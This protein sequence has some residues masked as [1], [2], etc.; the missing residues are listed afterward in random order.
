[1]LTFI[2]IVIVVAL[3]VVFA[4]V[5]IVPQG[6]QWTVER[7]G[8]YT[9]TLMPGLNP[10]VPFMDRIGRKINMMEQVLDI[11]SQE[12]ISRDNA[13]VAI[14]A[15]CF[16]RGRS[17]ARRLRGQQPRTGDR[18]PD[19]DQLP[20][21]ARLDGAGRNAVATRQHQQPPAAHRR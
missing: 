14:D 10:V 4:G 20:Y 13:N 19:H 21:R 16:I 18:Q 3:I 1:M 15:V 11:P 12:V 5:K 2:P 8:R 17:G 9:K 7:F 6:F